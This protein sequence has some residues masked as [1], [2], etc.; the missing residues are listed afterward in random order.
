MADDLE[1]GNVVRIRGLPWSA[2]HD[3]VQSFLDGKNQI[4]LNLVEVTSLLMYRNQREIQL[5]LIPLHHRTVRTT[6][7]TGNYVIPN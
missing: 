5:I 4:C 1:D 2:S 7:S 3:E 6:R